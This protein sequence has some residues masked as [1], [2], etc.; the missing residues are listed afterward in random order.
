MIHLNNKEVRFKFGKNWDNYLDNLNDFQINY[1]VRSLSKMLPKVDYKGKS[2]LDVGCGSGLS[3]LSAIKLG[4]K[5]TSFDYDKIS[6]ETTKRLKELYYKNEIWP[7]SQ[8]SILDEE[9]LSQLGKFD[10]VYSWGVLHHT[11]EMYNSFSNIIKLVKENGL[12]FIAIYND[13]GFRSIM[14]RKIKYFYSK[15][16][17]VRPLLNIFFLI[18]FWGP[19]ILVD[20][21]KLKPLKSWNDYKKRR[22]MSPY[23]DVIDWIGGY[24]FEVA[25]PDQVID[26]FSEKNFQ[27]IKLKTCG[28]KLGCNEFIFKKNT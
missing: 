19:K 2:F 22:G 13:Q 16:K 7:I 27:L 24:P 28:G 11:G 20:F 12:L 10:L 3:S 6:V 15:Y 21:L 23:F 26:Y 1:S 18:Y 9:Y 17:V 14:W 4:F 8:G 5:V 25:K